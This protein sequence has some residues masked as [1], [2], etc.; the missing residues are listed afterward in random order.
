[1][2]KP[3]HGVRSKECRLWAVETRQDWQQG[4]RVC[5][6]NPVFPLNKMDGH[7]MTHDMIWLTFNRR[8]RQNERASYK[9]VTLIQVRGDDVRSGWSLFIYIWRQRWNTSLMTE[10]KAEEWEGAQAGCWGSGSDQSKMLRKGLFVV[11]LFDLFVFHLT[12]RKEIYPVIIDH[13]T[14]KTHP[15]III[16]LPWITEENLVLKLWEVNFGA[17]IFHS[18]TYH[19]TLNLENCAQSKTLAK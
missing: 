5:C 19:Y 10:H 12:L 1:M 4:S 2:Q 14:M 3:W 6:E 18:K 13:I 9:G 15:V 8:R 7:K 17:P 16:S 11:S